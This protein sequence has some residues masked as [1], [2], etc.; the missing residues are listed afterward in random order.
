MKK[1]I[2]SITVLLTIG[3]VSMGGVG[4][5]YYCEVKR[6]L[7]ISNVQV[8][9]LINYN[10]IPK[11]FKFKW[12]KKSD[13]IEHLRL[14]DKGKRIFMFRFFPLKDAYISEKPKSYKGKNGVF[15]LIKL[16]WFEGSFVFS[17]STVYSHP[18]ELFFTNIG[19]SAIYAITAECTKF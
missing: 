9:N 7:S 3:S 18:F 1:I 2:I 8:L 5:V 4:D 13:D 6:N 15:T 17:G 10:P 19:I 16:K 11:I 14:D 12:E